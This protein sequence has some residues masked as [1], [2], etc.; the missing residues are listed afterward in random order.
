MPNVKERPKMDGKN[1]LN[2]VLSRRSA[3]QFGATGA[4]TILTGK[5]VQGAVT[6]TPT[7]T[8]GP[9]WVDELLN[10]SDVRGDRTGLP[11]YLTVNVSKLANAVATPLANAYVDIWHCDAAGNY[12]DEPAAM[13]NSNTQGQTWL[14]GYQITNAHGIVKFTTIYPGWYGGR[15][16]HIHAR[17]RFYSGTTTTLNMTTQ[18]FFDDTITD[19]VYSSISPYSTRG[20]TRDT[21]NSND[22]VYNTVSTGSTV[23][24]PDGS[25]LLLRMSKNGASSAVA[26]FNIVVA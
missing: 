4:A 5:I 10:R 14:R 13:G 15:T 12:S 9:Y 22:M 8:Q 1:L 20:R 6:T 16:A 3:L 19:L 18:F 26:S 25:R 23:A 17:V 2:T 11:F 24:S 7:E 21:R